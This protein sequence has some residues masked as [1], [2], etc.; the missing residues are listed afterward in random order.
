MTTL[1]GTSLWA[2]QFTT[3]SAASLLAAASP[4]AAELLALARER[5]SAVDGASESIEW[6]GLPWR[7]TLTFSRGGHEPA[8]AYLVPD[9]ATP[10][11]AVPLR[12]EIVHAIEPK[13]VSRAIRDEILACTHVAGVYWPSWEL[14]S[15]AVLDEA[16]K[17][18]ALKLADRGTPPA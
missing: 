14:T 5:L 6:L 2:D 7:W 10:R 18:V 12:H 4:P 15:R 8:L 17:L 3:P 13:S 11:I 1:A 16:M 9:P